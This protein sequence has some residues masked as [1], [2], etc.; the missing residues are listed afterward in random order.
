MEHVTTVGEKK[1]DIVQVGGLGKYKITNVIKYVHLDDIYILVATLDSELP[2]QKAR[3]PPSV[4]AKLSS[5]SRE[6]MYPDE[7]FVW[8]HVSQRI[9][10]SLLEGYD[11]DKQEISEIPLLLQVHSFEWAWRCLTYILGAK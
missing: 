6:R 1:G 10:P 8:P 9:W 4:V 7:W 11:Q 5:P 3:S 2:G